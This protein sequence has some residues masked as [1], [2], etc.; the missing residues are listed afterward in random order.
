MTAPAGRREPPVGTM[1]TEMNTVVPFRRYVA[2]GDSFTEGIGDPHPASRNGVRG[3]ADRVAAELA[4]G[5]PGFGYANLAIRGRTM[6]NI[7][8]HQIEPALLLEPDLVTVYAGMNDLVLLHNDIDR[9]MGRYAEALGALKRTGAVVVTFTAADLGT[10]PLFRRLR[11]RAA[12]YNELLRGIA[13]DLD[14]MLVD[15]WR[16]TEFR[17]RRLW[18]GD[19][20]HPSPLGHQHMAARV[21]DALAVP[22]R[23]TPDPALLHGP[24]PR[25]SLRANAR[26]AMSFAVPWVLRRLRRMTPGAGV[27][28]KSA[29]LDR[30]F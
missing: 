12:I 15:F 16:L 25:D 4:A 5:N 3:W 2:I 24:A 27:E 28:P 7:L 1:R 30:L 10:V 11:G 13:D 22:H 8:D 6:G 17:D 23:L 21:L 9:M 19:R 14:L 29:T 20:V 18:A 26:W